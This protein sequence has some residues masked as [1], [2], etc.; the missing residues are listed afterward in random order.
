[1]IYFSRP[2]FNLSAMLMRSFIA[3]EDRTLDM[4]YFSK[5]CTFDGMWKQTHGCMDT[6]PSEQSVVRSV[7]RERIGW[8]EKF[9]G[10]E[11]TQRR[12]HE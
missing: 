5:S 8:H 12:V 9:T 2:N 1:V 7:A 6:I 10:T 11:A 4:F 3:A